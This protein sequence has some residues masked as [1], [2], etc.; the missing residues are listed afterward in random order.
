MERLVPGSTLVLVIDVQ[1]RLA[2]AMPKEQ[3]AA[4]ERSASILLEAAK[5]LGAKVIATEQYPQGL[6]PTIP[7]VAEKLKVLEAPRLAKTTFSACDD[8]AIAKAIAETDARSV[9]VLGME[10]HV[11][12]FQTVRDLVKTPLAVYVPMDGV[13]SR[14]ED[15]RETG[16]SLCERAGAIR[17][18][19]ESI[20]FDWLKQAGSDDFRAISKLVK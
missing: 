12:V 3:M 11:C 19:T 18:T 1:E 17:T 9:V 13:A 7:S 6:G 10:T 8:E 14:R 4:L 20:V 16:L 2:A 15:H 5:V